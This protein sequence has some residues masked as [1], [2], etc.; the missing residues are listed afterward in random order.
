MPIQL[1]KNDQVL[2]ERVKDLTA[3]AYKSAHAPAALA[4]R[5]A[6]IAMQYRNRG[7]REAMERHP[8]RNI[9]EASGKP[10]AKEDKCLDECET[11]KG[12]EGR[13]RWVCPKANNNG[14]RSCGGC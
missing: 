5:I 9:C 1:D 11:E 14:L 7:R 6:G 2:V 12:Y 13:L 8:F 10:L 4:R 3:E